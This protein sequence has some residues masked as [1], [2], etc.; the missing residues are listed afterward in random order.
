VASDEVSGEAGG[1]PPSPSQA[2]LLVLPPFQLDSSNIRKEIDNS[3]QH[4][5]GQQFR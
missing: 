5:G 2:L 1:T 3:D 4:G